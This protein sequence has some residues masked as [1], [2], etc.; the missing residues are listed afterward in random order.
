[1]IRVGIVGFGLGGRVFHAPLVSSVEGLELVAIVDRSG[2]GAAE[3]YPGLAIYRSLEDMLAKAAIDLAVVTTPSGHHFGAARELLNADVN[4]VVDK[5]MAVS[6]AQIAELI[7]PA[8]KR[9]LLLS[10]FHNRR[11]DSDFLTLH[12]LLDEDCVGR[13]VGFESYFDRWRPVTKTAWKEDPAQGGGLLLDIGTHLVDQALVLFG[14]PRAV[15]AEVWRERDGDAAN[16]AFNLRLCYDGF[17]AALGANCLSAPGRPRYLLRGT[18]GN[19]TKWGLD[20]QEPALG[21]IT[22]IPPGPW[23]EEPPSTWGTLS[24]DV[25][26][27]MV[28]RPVAPIPGDYRLFY[29]GVRDALEGRAAAPVSAIDAWRTAKVLESAEQSSAQRREIECD[30]SDEPS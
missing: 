30:W 19:Y 16:D 2:R 3:R 14:K 21:Q 13:L 20:G 26:G 17:T 15:S 29:A 18:R 23:G 8:E 9:R 11:W 7:H 22:R 5:P 12:K 27:G 28:T 4:V 24:V 1:M 25:E 6:A 10:P